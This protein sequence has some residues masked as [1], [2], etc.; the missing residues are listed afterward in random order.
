[1]GTGESAAALPDEVVSQDR[2][3]SHGAARRAIWAHYALLQE[4]VA[5]PD[6]DP[7]DFAE[8]VH[9]VAT[10]RVEVAQCQPR[11]VASARILFVQLSRYFGEFIHHGP[12]LMSSLVLALR[13]DHVATPGGWPR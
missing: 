4:A 2:G 11:Y 12:K 10:K 9:V 8:V 6:V 1:M 3:V 13:P 5:E 7:K